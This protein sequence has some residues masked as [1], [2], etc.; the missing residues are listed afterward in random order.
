MVPPLE[1]NPVV[2]PTREALVDE[3]ALLG[4][5]QKP[6]VLCNFLLSAFQPI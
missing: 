3:A 2:A 1:S 5:R 6:E 4:L